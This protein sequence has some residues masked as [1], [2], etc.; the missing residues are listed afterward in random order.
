MSLS[1]APSLVD[2]ARAPRGR[3]LGGRGWVSFCLRADLWGF[4][5]QG[6]LDDDAARA[7]VTALS[8]ELGDDVAPHASIVD[9][10]RLAG[11]DPAVFRTIAVYVERHHG[12]LARQ[13]RRLAVVPG[14][15][16]E[17]AVV[18]GFFG[19]LPSPFPVVHVDDID[20]GL[21]ALALP[22]PRGLGDVEGSIAA[23][24][25]VCGDDD[26]LPERVRALL[27][28]APRTGP[29]DVARALSVSVR[30]LQ[31][32][33]TTA[34]TSLRALQAE[35]RL[36]LALARIRGSDAPLT[37]VAL[38]AGYASLQHMAR[39]V[40]AQTGSSPGALRAARGSTSAPR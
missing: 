2:F 35:V 17:G 26:V 5:V 25:T 36:E 38:D 23:A 11:V 20:A 30:S 10:S 16:L 6:R 3:F 40:R 31:R 24:L 1:R 21:R 12:A 8:V 19:V 39:A 32:G 15:G 22:E 18:A 9:M 34:G 27:R 37:T 7:L 29:A 13:V 14:R 4:A 33:L 28:G